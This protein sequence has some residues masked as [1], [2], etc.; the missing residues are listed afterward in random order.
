[1]DCN[2]LRRLFFIFIFGV[3]VTEF[4]LLDIQKL[5][6]RSL[7]RWVFIFLSNCTVYT[8]NLELFTMLKKYPKS[9]FPS[10]GF[11]KW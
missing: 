4:S 2:N 6:G 11:A 10:P 9:V 1:M 5:A 8:R 7:I 3:L